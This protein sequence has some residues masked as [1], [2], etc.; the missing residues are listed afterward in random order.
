MKEI[1]IEPVT[2]VEGH[3]LI[4]IELTENQIKNLKFSII[5]SPRFFEKLMIGRSAS[6]AP[7]LSQRICGICHVAHNLAA[8]KA[9]EAALNITPPE[10]AQLLRRALNDAGFITSHLLHIA[11]LA[12]PDYL[13]LKERS[14]MGIAKENPELAKKAIQI[15]AYGDKAT[16]I[17]GG[18]IVH[19]ATSIPGGMTKPLKEEER[20]ILL[21]E[22]EETL[23]V[24]LEFAEAAIKTILESSLLNDLPTQP[25][26]YLS[27]TKD[28]IHEIYDGPVKAIKADGSQITQFQ[29]QE[30]LQ[31]IAEKTCPYSYAK[32]PYLKV[33]G[34]PKGIYRVGPIARVNIADKFNW[35][36][37]EE[38]H[39]NLVSQFKK[40]IHS[41]AAINLARII[42]LVASVE[43]L[44]ALLSNKKISEGQVRVSVETRAG[45]GVGIV[46][47]PRGTL[48]HHY[49][50]NDKGLIT[51]ANFIVPTTENNPVIEQ[52]LT[53]YAEKSVTKLY[54]GDADALWR[55]EALIRAYDPCISCATHMIK[56]KR[57]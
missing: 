32:H 40:P 5:E 49:K 19:T 2:R 21:K 33:L 22:G 13:N 51:Q 1:K 7:H 14:F 55:L 52:D 47:A 44:I 36:K 43:E 3:A 35:D 17:L 10:T 28:G 53:R 39:K 42:E 46:E 11:F 16:T 57:I 54:N 31:H 50:I 37:S 9:V 20:K 4:T 41:I 8:V 27:I 15:H 45:E 23:G 12:L 18:K 25:R 38:L 29:P 34:Y 24:A 56:I 48:I 6:E 26:N 30:Y